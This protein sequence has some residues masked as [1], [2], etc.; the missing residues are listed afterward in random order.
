MRRTIMGVF[1]LSMVAAVAGADDALS[2]AS[3]SDCLDALTTVH[4]FDV[5]EGQNAALKSQAE[6]TE[7][8]LVAAGF[9]ADLP[10]DGTFGEGFQDG[11]WTVF[12]AG[13]T[14]VDAQALRLLV[15]LSG[16]AP[17]DRLW[18]V[19]PATRSSLGLYTSKDHVPGGRWLPTTEGDLT[20]LVLKTK[21]TAPNVQILGVS[22]FY[23]G[24]TAL[25][26]VMSCH[27][28]IACED[29]AIQDLGKGVGMMVIPYGSYDQAVCSGC[30]IDNSRK[31]PYFLTA[32]HCVPGGL[33]AWN[34]DIIWDFKAAACDGTGIPPVATLPRS[35][36]VALLETDSSLDTTLM[37]L[38]E[39]PSD[40]LYLP[41]DRRD[42]VVGE[43]VICIHHPVA[44]PGSPTPS[45]STCHMRV[46]TGTVEGIN[47][48]GT[49]VGLTFANET[50]VHWDEG[51]TE[52]GSSGSCL[53][54]RDT[55]G[56][57]KVTG[58]LS[59]GTTHVCGTDRTNNVDWYSSFRHFY[60]A[61]EGY[62]MGSPPAAPTNVRAT[63]GA[64]RAS[65]EVTWDAVPEATSYMLY[66]S[67]YDD[68]DGDLVLL[69]NAITG[70][71]YTDQSVSPAIFG[72][73]GGSSTTYYYW[74]RA[75][76]DDGVSGYS[77][78][79]TGYA[80]KSAAEPV[81]ANVS[82]DLLVLLA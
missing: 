18:L 78:P 28:N 43:A 77:E 29:Q 14:S 51:G 72:C 56:N 82:G 36:G 4:L 33:D 37:L 2:A 17:E 10:A 9:A 8:M 42:P 35:G 26:A 66:R 49:Q 63:D 53:L 52:G 57:Y 62:L 74:V 71:S 55:E 67:E 34:V 15:D 64:N 1:V 12:V 50:K 32:W 19:D 23:L 16:M 22:H 38:D 58:T 40:R 60:A 13:V 69:A 6:G 76:N 24:F 80:G 46:S 30:L 5:Y 31:N 54:F 41:W 61:I 11:D 25:K 59:G 81:S 39:V 3:V 70:T 7:P 44:N 65:I 47:T 48:V 21:G 68:T 75:K 45:I 20:V 27:I 73:F 79:D